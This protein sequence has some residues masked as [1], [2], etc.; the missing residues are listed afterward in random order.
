MRKPK[1]RKTFVVSRISRQRE[2]N[3]TADAWTSKSGMDG[4]NHTLSES[5]SHHSFGEHS[6]PHFRRGQ[7]G[8]SLCQRNKVG[9]R[10]A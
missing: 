10:A 4:L 6:E 7:Q 2:E 8:P 1:T 5:L 9:E 3:Q